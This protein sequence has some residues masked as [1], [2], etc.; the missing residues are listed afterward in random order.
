MSLFTSLSIAK[1]KLKELEDK[2]DKEINDMEPKLLVENYNELWGLLDDNRSDFL[3]N[4]K[5]LKSSLDMIVST[6]EDH[7]ANTMEGLNIA[8]T[9]NIEK[10]IS[11]FE[12]LREDIKYQQERGTDVLS[13]ILQ[14]E[15]LVNNLRWDIDY[16]LAY[17]E[18]LRD[19][20]NE[21]EE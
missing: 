4:I 10:A 5:E 1:L 12:G 9:E 13:K 15:L 14:L 17:G 2:L 16:E 21:E 3:A 6:H 19:L 18:W 20:L 7:I 8:H 11:Y